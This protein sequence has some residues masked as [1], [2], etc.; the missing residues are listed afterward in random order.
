MRIPCLQR[1][2]KAR[3]FFVF[4]LVSLSF[5]VSAASAATI[6]GHV[7][8]PD[9][10]DVPAARV[11]IATSIGTAAERT[12]DATGHFVVDTL[13]AG[14]YDVLVVANGLAADPMTIVLSR[15]EVRD[16]PVMLHLSGI[17]E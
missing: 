11:V 9:G 12:T 4:S 8:D 17:T 3:R 7:T 6:T 16:I 13:G 5:F 14:R 1:L 2:A 10:R 15:D